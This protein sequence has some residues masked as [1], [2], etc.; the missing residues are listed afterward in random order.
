MVEML[1]IQDHFPVS[2]GEPLPEEML[3]QGMIIAQALEDRPQGLGTLAPEKD[4]LPLE[5]LSS[6]EFATDR[7]ALIRRRLSGEVPLEAGGGPPD[8][9]DT[10]H[11]SVMDAEGNAVALTSSIGPAFGAAVAT[12]NLGFLYAHS[13][14]MHSHPAPGARDDTEMT[15]T[16]VLDGGR[17]VLAIGAAGSQRIPVAIYQVVVNLFDRGFSLRR[18]VAAPRVYCVGERAWVE[19]GL[20]EEVIDEFESRGYSVTIDSAAFHLGR[21]HAVLFDPQRGR[22]N[23]A[24]DPRYD[25]VTGTPVQR[26]LE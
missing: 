8:A 19:S 16:I 5:R 23:G 12:P 24:A 11:L 17:P 10:T 20:S 21:V 1:N 15:P 7:A 6:P 2:A 9:H 14:R 25:G 3:I 22:F 26:S 18:A 13:Y 4:G